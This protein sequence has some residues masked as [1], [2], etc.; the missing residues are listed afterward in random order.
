VKFDIFIGS[1]F[2]S[3]Y[4]Y[5]LLVSEKLVLLVGGMTQGRNA[6]FSE[7]VSRTLIILKQALFSNAAKIVKSDFYITPGP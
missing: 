4:A 3:L 1:Y 2:A 5:R 6:F 7:V